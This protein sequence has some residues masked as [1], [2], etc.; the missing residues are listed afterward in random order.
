MEWLEVR[1][2]TGTVVWK[3]EELAS[4]A[5]DRIENTVKVLDMDTSQ[6]MGVY[7][8]RLGEKAVLMPKGT[9]VLEI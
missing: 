7:I 6:M 2:A 3:S 8:L 9:T 1:D 4:L 5:V